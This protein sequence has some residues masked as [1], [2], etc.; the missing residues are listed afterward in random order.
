MK[1][2]WFEWLQKIIRH[3]A[4]V[5][6]LIKHLTAAWETVKIILELDVATNT[7]SVRSGVVLALDSLDPMVR[8]FVDAV[9]EEVNASKLPGALAERPFLDFLKLLMANPAFMKFIM[10]LLMGNKT[11]AE[12]QAKLAAFQAA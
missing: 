8:E 9:V 10:D 11:T 4:D 1:F 7:I 6:T 2:N 12:I 5:P 3:A